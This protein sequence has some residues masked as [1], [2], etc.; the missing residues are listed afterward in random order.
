MYQRAAKTKPASMTS[1]DGMAQVAFFRI[2]K[3]ELTKAGY[4]DPAFYFEQVE[5]WLRSGK[6]LPST[7]REVGKVLGL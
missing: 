6:G 7:A 4:E 5:D 1:M 2:A 3:E